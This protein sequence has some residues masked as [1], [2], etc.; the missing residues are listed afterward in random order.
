MFSY[1]GWP[2][3][4]PALGVLRTYLPKKRRLTGWTF[5]SAKPCL[6][7]PAN[8]PVRA[9]G[10]RPRIGGEPNKKRDAAS[11]WRRAVWPF[12]SLL[13]DQLQTR[14]VTRR[15]VWWDG[16]PLPRP[17]CPQVQG[18]PHTCSSGILGDGNRASSRFSLT[19]RCEAPHDQPMLSGVS[20]P[21]SGQSPVR[22]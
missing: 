18:L 6:T 17:Y 10:G 14:C 13:F 3:L 7:S 19:C 11:L 5:H 4:L 9:F 2:S 20:W 21:V 16:N 1:T 15:I 8:L 22:G 12:A